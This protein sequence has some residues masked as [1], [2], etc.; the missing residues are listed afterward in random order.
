MDQVP[1][2]SE[3]KVIGKQDD[4]NIPHDDQIEILEES[5]GHRY[6]ELE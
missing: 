4:N 3:I 6:H 2:H 1:P 5:L